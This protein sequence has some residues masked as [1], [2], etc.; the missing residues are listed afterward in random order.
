MNE[1]YMENQDAETESDDWKEEGAEE[2][3][4]ADEDDEIEEEEN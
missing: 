1:E 2:Q 3:K 4:E